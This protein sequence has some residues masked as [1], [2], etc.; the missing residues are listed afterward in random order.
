MFSDV[1]LTA[2]IQ[3]ASGVRGP[4]KGKL[5]VANGRFLTRRT[6]APRDARRSE[7]G[8]ARDSYWTGDKG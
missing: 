7:L 6:F 8:D 3:S 4:E 5:S 1:W 2:A